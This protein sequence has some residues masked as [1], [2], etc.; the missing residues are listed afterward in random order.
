VF[1]PEGDVILCNHFASFPVGR[2]GVD[3]E[4]PDEF[5]VFWKSEDLA[6]IRNRSILYPHERCQTC[7]DWDICGGGCFV[8]WM[9]WDPRTYIPRKEV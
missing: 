6:E 2:F 9:H 7:S 4:T 8:K 1:S 3:F 5:A